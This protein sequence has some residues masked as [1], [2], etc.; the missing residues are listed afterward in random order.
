D[1][2]LQRGRRGRREFHQEPSGAQIATKLLP[3]QRLDIRLVIDNQN[4]NAQCAPPILRSAASLRGSVMMNSVNTPGSVLT[5]MVPPCCF[6][7]MSCL[8]ESPSPVPS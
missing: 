8:I 3:K 1:R 6:T 4:I 7:T 2:T 5:S